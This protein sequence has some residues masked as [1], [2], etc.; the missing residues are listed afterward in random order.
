LT[1]V[2]CLRD[3]VARFRKLFKNWQFANLDWGAPIE[4]NVPNLST[5]ERLHLQRH[6][7]RQKNAGKTLRQSL[8]YLINDDQAQSEIQL[9]QYADFHRYFPYFIKAI[10]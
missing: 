7:P 2:V 8:G 10:P 1:G 4:I 3:H 5:K 9:Q 6:L